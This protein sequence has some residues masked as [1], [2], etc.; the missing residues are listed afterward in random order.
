M[1]ELER[2]PRT[3]NVYCDKSEFNRKFC[4]E[5]LWCEEHINKQ[6][7][8][9]ERKNMKRTRKNYKRTVLEYDPQL[10][11]EMNKIL[12]TDYTVFLDGNSKEIF[13]LTDI[14]DKI[15]SFYSDSCL[16]KNAK[17]MELVIDNEDYQVC[18]ISTLYETLTIYKK[19]KND[20]KIDFD[21]YDDTQIYKMDITYKK[22]K[23]D[24]LKI[25]PKN[26]YSLE[27]TAHKRKMMSSSKT[28]SSN[29]KIKLSDKYNMPVKTIETDSYATVVIKNS[30]IKIT[31]EKT[32][33]S[34]V[35]M[36]KEGFGYRNYIIMDDLEVFLCPEFMSELNKIQQKL[37]TITE[38]SVVKC[39]L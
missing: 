17:Q 9:I 19:S 14:A 38:K 39:D 16:H 29:K 1:C 35:I 20:F 12:K 36:C 6:K 3:I 28:I 10:F 22:W 11:D 32:N 5:N 2:L 13:E 31:D 34:D 24:H 4:I 21:Y 27:K 30:E 33:L 15:R 8:I 18:E 26:K 7:L 23:Y 25:C 37:Y